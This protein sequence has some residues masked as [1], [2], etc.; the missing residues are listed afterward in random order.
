MGSRARLVFLV[1]VAMALAGCAQLVPGGDD[2]LANGWAHEM[3]QADALRDEGLT[4][5]GV[6]IG[7]VDTGVHVDH[8]AFADHQVPWLDV[9]NDRPEPYDDGGH[10]THVSGLAVA[11]E[12]RGFA[13]PNVMGIAPGADLVHAKAI[14][15][16]GGGD[17]PDVAEAIDW[18][19]E[20]RVD[21][22]VLS[23]GQQ[24]RLLP[25][26]DAVEDAVNDALDEGIVVVAAAGNAR[27]GDTGRDCNLSSPATVPLV[28]AVGAVDDEGEIARF[29]CTGGDRHGPLGVQQRGDPNKKPEVSAPG[30][31]LVGAWPERVCG[32]QVSEYCVLSGTS[33]ATPIVGGI[34]ALLLEANPELKSG[35]RATVEHVK[36]AFMMTAKKQGFDGH[37][38]RYGY[39]IVQGADALTWLEQHEVNRDGGGGL[40]SLP[41]PSAS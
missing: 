7:I 25:I 36:E 9:V 23:L 19:V 4:G 31:G 17:G 8:P 39:G 41:L 26:G 11:Q 20:Q 21:V 16:D 34:V 2:R 37:H 29:S 35:D 5:E 12:T 28:I 10:G 18:M 27:D 38:D 3:V 14:R 30:V 6:T 1:A 13:G 15:G 32:N 33:Q 24:P 40:P 22:L